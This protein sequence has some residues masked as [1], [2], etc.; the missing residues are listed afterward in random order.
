MI[1][2]SRN[3][4]TTSLTGWRALLATVVSFAVA[5]LLFVML[6]VFVLGVAIT[7]SALLI[8]L[9][10]AALVVALL[11]WIFQAAGTRVQDR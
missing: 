4:R 9:V 10:P 8:L 3:G 1:V 11:G 5:F 7:M 2:I 6:A